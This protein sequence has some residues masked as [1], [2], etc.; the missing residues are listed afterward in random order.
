L[1]HPLIHEENKALR[2][3]VVNLFSSAYTAPRESNIVFVCGGNGPT[4]MRQRFLEHCKKSDIE[5]EIFQPEFSM[6]NYFSSGSK[7]PFDIADFEILV[8]NL[9]KAIVIFPEAAGSYAE[10]GYFSAKDDLAAKSLLVMDSYYQNKDSFIS[11]GPAKKIE[12]KT[13]FYPV[14]QMSYSN[15]NFED[16]LDRIRKRKRGEYKKKLSWS[17]LSELSDYEYFCLIQ[18]ITR[19]LSAVTISDLEFILRA[20]SNSRLSVEKI[21]HL[22][23]ILVGSGYLIELGDFGHLV[24]NEAKPPLLQ[25]RDG[26]KTEHTEIQILLSSLYLDADQEFRELLEVI[27]C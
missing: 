2:R 26:R 25:I 5:F 13:L 19:A 22:T 1:D 27:N 21:H 11:M 8:G 23:S 15:P 17:L 12:K 20:L 9:S 14:V 16:L 3:R 6:D 4:D 10:T 7:E 18:E 24:A